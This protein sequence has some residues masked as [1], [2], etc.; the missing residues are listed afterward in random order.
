MTKKIIS[1]TSPPTSANIDT[2]AI[3]ASITVPAIVGTVIVPSIV[4]AV[5]PLEIDVQL[6]GLGEDYKPRRRNSV[7][8]PDVLDSYDIRWSEF[9]KVDV[10]TYA[11][12]DVAYGL[13]TKGVEDIGITSDQLI[14]QA[15]FHRF[16]SEGVTY[17]AEEYTQTRD[18]TLILN[19]VYDVVN[20]RFDKGISELNTLSEEV[21]K[22]GL[23]T[24]IDNLL[25]S[26]KL[27]ANLSKVTSDTFAKTDSSNYLAIGKIVV[28]SSSFFELI[29]G[30]K[31]NYF[32]PGYVTPGYV[33]LN[34]T[35]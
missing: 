23:R 6:S 4:T 8:N 3:S 13:F 10:D 27:S 5:N 31:Q 24:T 32:E 9:Q 29:S 14:A 15:Y 35:L 20:T 33:G 18:Y 22:A 34:Y 11:Y 28:E 7:Y 21:S 16:F 12:S 26:D 1:V 25:S 30:N 17:F 2:T 19:A